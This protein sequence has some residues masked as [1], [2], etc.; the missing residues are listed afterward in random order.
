MSA[1]ADRQAQRDANYATAYRAWI[2]SLP[3]AE[4]AAL[5]AAGLREPDASRHT[6]TRQHDEATLDRTAAPELTPDDLAEQ[7]DEPA[8]VVSP[9]TPAVCAADVLASFCARIRAHPH[10]LLAFDAACFASG[11]M[12]VEGLSESALAE[13]HGVTRAAFS[14]LVVQWADL[15]G[16]QPSRGMRSKRARRAYRRARLTFLAQHHDQAAA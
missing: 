3:P 14:K 4:R 1:Y 2:A 15:F 11:L 5:D 16:L 9:S 13:R 12:D 10:P 6:S 7:A 8:L